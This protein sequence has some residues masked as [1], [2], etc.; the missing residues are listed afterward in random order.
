[1]GLLRTQSKRT[2][3][4]MSTLTEAD[5]SLLRALEAK[6]QKHIRC[7]AEGQTLSL[8]E[9]RKLFIAS[10]SHG[11]IRKQLVLAKRD[12]YYMCRDLFPS[13]ISVHR[14]RQLLGEELG[15]DVND[16][17][18]CQAPKGLMSG[19]L[20]FRDEMNQTLSLNLCGPYAHIPIRP[21]RLRDISTTAK[22]ILV[23]EKE[24]AFQSL[25]A[26][27]QFKQLRQSLVV[28]TG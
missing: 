26:T 22:L 25:I 15:V 8:V 28:L 4:Q 14:A 17:C 24:C 9:A 1:M 2:R 18:I 19:S 21:E 23:I 12:I 5:K 20:S 7:T 6:I 13:V 16:L 27:S 11:L 10:L 3:S